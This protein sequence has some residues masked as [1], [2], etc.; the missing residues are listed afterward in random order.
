[1]SVALWGQELRDS[2]VVAEG[3]PRLGSVRAHQGSETVIMS[4]DFANGIPT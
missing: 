4:E 2:D 1:M 3:L